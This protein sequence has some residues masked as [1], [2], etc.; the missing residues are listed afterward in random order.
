MRAHLL[1]IVLL[2]AGWASVP[3]P[4]PVT[5]STS[6]DGSMPFD[7]SPPH[8]PVLWLVTTDR[9]SLQEMMQDAPEY[10][11]VVLDQ[12][13]W[14]SVMVHGH[15]SGMLAWTTAHE[16]VHHTSVPRSMRMATEVEPNLPLEVHRSRHLAWGP[17][18]C[19]SD[20]CIHPD[21]LD[22]MDL[23]RLMSDPSVLWVQPLH[24]LVLHD[25]SA[26]TAIGRDALLTGVPGTLDGSGETIAV[27]DTGIDRDH[28]DFSGRI[29]GVDTS[30]GL[31][32]SPADSNSGHGTHVTGV[33]A[34]NGSGNAST[35]G[36]LPAAFIRSYALEYDATGTFGRFG[37]IYDM[38][39]S[40]D[41]VGSRV[42][43]NAWG[44]SGSYGAYN[45][46]SRSIDTFVRDHPEA[47]VVFSVGDRG[48]DGASQISP[49]S[50]AKNALAVGASDGE[51][52][53]GFSSQGPSLDGRVRPDVLAPGVD[54]CASR[55]QE[56]SIV[57]GGPCGD[58]LHADGSTPL[59]MSLSGTSQAAPVAAGAAGLVR[60]H[61]RESLGINSPTAALLK[62]ALINGAE[63]L[64]APNIPNPQE[65]WGR[66][67]LERTI[68]PHHDGED[69][70][71][72][73][74]QSKSLSAGESLI[75]RFQA[76][77]TH[78]LDLTLTW[79][80][81]PG[82]S[83]AA[84]STPRLINDL[85]LK[86]I[87]PDGTEYLGNVF[88]NGVSVVGGDSDRLNNVERVRIP[89]DAGSRSGVWSVVVTN[90]AGST[91][92]FAL[93]VTGDVV[94]IPTVDLTSISRSILP[95]SASPL[96]NDLIS[97]QVAWRN[98]GTTA[99]GSFRVLLEDLTTGEILLNALEPG[100]SAGAIDARTIYASFNTTGLHELRLSIDS[101]DDVLEANDGTNGV[102][103]NVVD[104][105]LNVSALGVRL[106]PFTDEGLEATTDAEVQAA[107]Q[108]R[109][110][111]RNTSEIDIPLIL[112]HEGTGQELIQIG[113]TSV[114][115]ASTAF[116]GARAPTIDEWSATTNLSASMVSLAPEGDSGDELPL[117]L[118]LANL[119]ADPSPSDPNLPSRYIR[120]GT[121]H[122][123]LTARY[124]NDTFVSDTLSFTLVVDPI[125]DVNIAT[126]G[127]SDLTVVPG[128]ETMFS[129]SVRNI[130]NSPSQYLLSCASEARWQVRLGTSDSDT[131]AFEDLDIL[132]YL[133]MQV[134][135]RAPTIIDGLPSEGTT[136]RITCTVTSPS[137]PSLNETRTAVVTVAGSSAFEVR[138]YDPDGDPVPPSLI[139]HD[140]ASGSGET[141][142]YRLHLENKGNR[143]IDLTVRLTPSDLLWVM[144]VIH[145]DRSDLT[146]LT[147]T[148][149]PGTQTNLTIDVRV[150]PT[151]E[152]QASNNLRIETRLDDSVFVENR[153]SVTVRDVLS[154]EVE[155]PETID[156]RPLG[157]WSYATV[158]LTNT[159]TTTVALDIDLFDG[160]MGWR[161]EVS[162]PPTAISPRE[163]VELTLAFEAPE[164][165][166]PGPLV[167][168][169]SLRVNGSTA[170]DAIELTRSLDLMV[171]PTQAATLRDADGSAVLPLRDVPQSG[172]VRTLTF[173]N[174]GNLPANLTFQVDPPVEGWSFEFEPPFVEGLPV[175][176]TTD[177][178]VTAI[179]DASAEAAE[180]RI[181]VITDGSEAVVEFDVRPQVGTVGGLSGLIGPGPSAALILVLIILGGV[182]VLRNRGR[183]GPPSDQAALVGPD[184]AVFEAR[185][186]EVLGLGLATDNLATGAVDQAEIAA[187]LA[188]SMDLPPLPPPGPVPPPAGA[189]PLPIPPA[190]RPPAVPIAPP[191]PAMPPGVPPVPPEGLPPGWTMDQWIHYGAQFLAQRGGR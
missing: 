175:G 51:Q 34:G 84:Q 15:E 119:D 92:P 49:Q 135:V 166:S 88:S 16:A 12:V 18:G 90:V 71:T 101:D 137:D 57:T 59:S 64:G 171:L 87:A 83:G 93:A 165:T 155:A 17:F 114:Q 172:A 156:V 32:S 100:L 184:E 153:T 182:V 157:T 72:W 33:I 107:T 126:A 142:L 180:V 118:T 138:L 68:A 42:M 143:P 111:A 190:G 74:D 91:Q 134:H 89:A 82:S 62:A 133:P 37:S 69:L 14:D 167:R 103:N 104:L 110:D 29:L 112:R 50:S 109:I 141:H 173:R 30:F 152:R 66:V 81:A 26:G 47:M 96:V 25:A 45:G 54:I 120:A 85:D 176:S 58:G 86:L 188:Q 187:A 63:D 140:H 106:V 22:P 148:L 48:G 67:D 56:A 75:Y 4:V 41:S 132:E 124:L 10:D 60:E 161:T 183:R 80:D 24:D 52:R 179:P 28:P 95:S 77:E 151:A 20:R 1:L 97:I 46:D 145:E 70:T 98:Q 150:P 117:L 164:G 160:P 105:D 19:G 144:Q 35:A 11:L 43:V 139:G 168:A 154:L 136:D 147:V 27:M 31:D 65:G 9:A 73:Y 39:N 116:V 191:P 186:S 158:N 131:L 108:L 36:L 40:A 123:D 7:E 3:S 55:A 178:Q 129:V 181:L 102:D 8:A 130:G 79:T 162:A 122:V 61:L 146:T 6:S 169:V 159:G 76:N 13:G 21:G 189:P 99:A 23:E 177:V 53:A 115:R 170:E 121:Y 5:G 125:R 128:D 127:T 2:T 38:L 78:G 149:Q 113:L 44:S 94:E 163:R 185:R 174:V